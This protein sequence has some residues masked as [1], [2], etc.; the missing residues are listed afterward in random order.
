MTDTALRQLIETWRE[1]ASQPEPGNFSNTAGAVRL[2]EFRR[3]SLI[4]A[5][6]AN[7]LEAVLQGASAPLQGSEGQVQSP[8]VRE[9]RSSGSVSLVNDGETIKEPSPESAP[10][11]STPWRPIATA[12]K[13]DDVLL[14]EE[15]EG[16]RAG[17]WDDLEA[18]DPFWRAVETQGCTTGRMRPTHWMP[19]PSP[20]SEST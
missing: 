2:L 12:P 20:P 14:Y 6:C 7:E 10:L 4:Y 1:L 19:L 17:Y 15:G 5:T 13:D 9:A 11:P 8:A 16:V 3:Q 18:A